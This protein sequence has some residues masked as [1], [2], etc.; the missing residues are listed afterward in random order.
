MI[1]LQDFAKM[2]GVTD[3]AVQKHLKKHEKALEGH[4]ERLGPNG[5]YLDDFACEFIRER[6]LKAPV[7]ISQVSEEVEALKQENNE[8]KDK[9]LAAQELMLQVQPQLQEL[10][11]YKAKAQF[12]LESKEKAELEVSALNIEKAQ[13]QE[14]LEKE[15]TRRISFKEWLTRRK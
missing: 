12:Y 14:D 4:F 1:K 8:L 6:M 3:R 15:K 9:L 10:S 13:L 11:E 7:V 2:Q 5:T